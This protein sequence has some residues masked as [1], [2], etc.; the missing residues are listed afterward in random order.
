MPANY[1]FDAY[2]QDDIYYDGETLIS[3]SAENNIFLSA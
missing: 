3:F 1:Y 2:V